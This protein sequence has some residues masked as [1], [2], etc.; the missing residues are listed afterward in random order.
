MKQLRWRILGYVVAVYLLTAVGM[1]WLFTTISER[2]SVARQREDLEQELLV[3]REAVDGES[4]LEAVATRLRDASQYSKRRI[5]LVLPEGEVFYDSQMFNQPHDNHGDRTEIQEALSRVGV[6][7][8]ERQSYMTGEEMLYSSM[9]LYDA[10]G[11]VRAILRLSSATQM[12]HRDI[13]EM[14]LLIGGALV[15]MIV[16]TT[17]MTYYWTLRITH[18]LEELKQ[19]AGRMSQHDYSARYMADSY[20]DIEELGD[21]FNQLAGNLELHVAEVQ[22]NE[23][24]IRELINH[25]IIGVMLINDADHVVMVNP[26][27]NEILGRNVYGQVGRD[28]GELIQSAELTALI[29][30]TMHK[31]QSQNQEL[32]LYL[33][34]ERLVDV[35]VIPIAERATDTY[36]YIVLLY[37]I[38]E[39][40]RLEKVRT[41]FVANASHELKTPITALKGFSETL[42]D[43][44]MNDR[45]TLVDFLEIMAKESARLDAMVQDILQLSKLERQT[46]HTLAERV[47]VSEVLAEVVQILQQKIEMKEITVHLNPLAELSVRA[48]RDELKQVLINLVSN[49]VHYTA[50]GGDVW[51][52]SEAVAGEV[53]IQVEDNGIGIPLADQARIFERFYRVDKARSRNAGG[54]GLG[55]S[56][57]KWLVDGM[58]GRIELE[59]EPGIGTL[60]TV[61]LP[62]A[63]EEK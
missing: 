12:L 25:L 5:T 58:E 23:Q 42:L 44:A 59:S 62:L 31:K 38:T 2:E 54:T 4:S 26:V 48:N 27:I 50:S 41:D 20:R 36:Q 29:E 8:V 17:V 53:Q 55:L 37:D 19:V 24:R 45:E 60:F 56:I 10:N 7:T 35:N 3:M 1:L 21:A 52:R 15:V 16:L 47:E 40:R 6:A 14:V 18:P 57:V 34:Q 39:I 46:G 32:T 11:E 13:S 22:R 51:L 9:A 49:A 63:S 30:R 33:E 61:Y 43:G 28:Y